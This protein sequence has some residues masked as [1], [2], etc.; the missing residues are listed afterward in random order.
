M[1]KHEHGTVIA[2][3]QGKS[4]GVIGGEKERN[5]GCFKC[6]SPRHIARFCQGNERIAAANVREGQTVQRNSVC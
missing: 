4:H 1:V 3:S 2:N 6:G 5:K